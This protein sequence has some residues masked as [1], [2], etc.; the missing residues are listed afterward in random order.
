MVSQEEENDSWEAE[1]AGDAVLPSVA[2][3]RRSSGGGVDGDSRASSEEDRYARACAALLKYRRVAKFVTGDD[4]GSA[5]EA[6]VGWLDARLLDKNVASL[7]RAGLRPEHAVPVVEALR[8]GAGRAMDGEGQAFGGLGEDMVMAI[9]LGEAAPRKDGDG[10]TGGAGG[11]GAVLD[12]AAI[13]EL[14]M[15]AP[16]GPAQ[17][18]PWQK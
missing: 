4:K 10:T 1:G 5:P 8:E 9:V 14:S 12:S 15:V 17:T 3:G 16:A 2:S 7:Y 18:G 13:E 11:E 6:I